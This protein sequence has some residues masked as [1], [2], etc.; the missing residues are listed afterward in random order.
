MSILRMIWFPLKVVKVNK[1]IKIRVVAPFS[2]MTRKVLPN[3]MKMKRR[4]R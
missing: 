2:K 3:K 1:I 4:R